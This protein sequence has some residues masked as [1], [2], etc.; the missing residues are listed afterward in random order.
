MSSSPYLRKT[1]TYRKL[2]KRIQTSQKNNQKYAMANHGEKT[3]PLK[4]P[5]GTVV[6]LG[7]PEFLRCFGI[8]RESPPVQTLVIDLTQQSQQWPPW[9]LCVGGVFVK[10]F[11]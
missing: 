7:E 3:H 11:C 8:P 6:F 2:N 4:M 5:P 1:T 9:R 10:S